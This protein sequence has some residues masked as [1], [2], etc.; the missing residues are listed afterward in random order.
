[1]EA[2]VQAAPA[3]NALTYSKIYISCRAAVAFPSSHGAVDAR[4][5]GWPEAG[6]VGLCAFD[7]AMDAWKVAR[8][9]HEA[10]CPGVAGKSGFLVEIIE[11]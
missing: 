3:E 10:F 6:A 11:P 4:D 1:M 8:G 5:P 2:E 7:L 9:C